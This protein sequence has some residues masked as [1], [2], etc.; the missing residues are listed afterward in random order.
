MPMEPRDGIRLL[1]GT[2]TSAGLCVVSLYRMDRDRGQQF[3]GSSVYCRQDNIE[4]LFTARHVVEAV[5][6]ERFLY[7]CYRRGRGHLWAV[8]KKKGNG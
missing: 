6:P 8:R 2:L 3:V 5:W 7:P 4:L 1:E